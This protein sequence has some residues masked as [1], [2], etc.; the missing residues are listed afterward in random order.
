MKINLGAGPNW[1]QS[2]WHI[3][4]YKLQKNEKFKIKGNLNKI[5]LKDKICEQVFISHTLEHIPHIQ[6]QNVLT[7][8]NRI[9]KKNAV[10]RILVPNLEKI[11]K[12]YVKKDKN[13]FKK[14]LR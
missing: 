12:A 8:I 2:G 6:I 1:Y 9:M 3:L 7:E 5:N 11:A 10:I 13:F 14:S 4:D